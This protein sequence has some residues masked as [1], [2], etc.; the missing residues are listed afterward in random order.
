V[1]IARR[2]PTKG[3]AP[4]SPLPARY[5]DWFMLGAVQIAPGWHDLVERLFADLDA[6]LSPAERAAFQVAALRERDGRLALE[7][8][9]PVPAAAALIKQAIKESTRICQNC[10]APGRRRSFAGWAATLCAPCR[11]RL[12]AMKI[13]G[14]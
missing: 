4:D 11:Q 3:G 6:S 2:I 9:A 5:P 13:G 8:Y 14:G 1:R 7:T 12:G 10:G